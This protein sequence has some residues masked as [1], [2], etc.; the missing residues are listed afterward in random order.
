VLL[1]YDVNFS[2]NKDLDA[3]KVEL[4]LGPNWD[5]KIELTRSGTFFSLTLPSLSLIPPSFLLT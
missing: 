3:A 2:W 4:A 5:E 1:G